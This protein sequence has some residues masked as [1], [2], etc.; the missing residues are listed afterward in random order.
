MSRKNPTPPKVK[1]K[2]GFHSARV[3]GVTKGV[4]GGADLS[5]EETNDGHNAQEGDHKKRRQH[6]MMF[7]IS[8]VP[9]RVRKYDF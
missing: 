6:Q 9:E 8:C 2:E 3:H 1:V 7:N 4:Q 5:T